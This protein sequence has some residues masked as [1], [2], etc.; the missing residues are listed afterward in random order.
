MLDAVPLT[1]QLLEHS[2]A[3]ALEGG[4]FGVLPPK[5]SRQLL[6]ASIRSNVLV[7]CFR[8]GVVAW[9]L[10]VRLP[11]GITSPNDS[12]ITDSTAPVNASIDAVVPRLLP[13]RRCHFHR[14]LSVVATNRDYDE[15]GEV[16]RTQSSLPKLTGYL[17][18]RPSSRSGESNPGPPPYHGGALPTE[19]LRRLED[20]NN[21]APR[22]RAKVA[23]WTHAPSH[24]RRSGDAVRRLVLE[25]LPCG[26]S[27]PDHVRH[28]SREPRAGARRGPGGRLPRRA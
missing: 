3:P 26:R 8:S 20:D 27:V 10:Q 19:L 6:A 1:V 22:T 11:V 2:D 24:H 23:R 17:Q 15:Y 14:P 18:V 4:G 5:S 16:S 9:L 28:P 25:G 7:N 12:A 21:V 13:R